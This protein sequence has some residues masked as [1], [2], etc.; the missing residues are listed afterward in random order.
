LINDSTY[1]ARK[2]GWVLVEIALQYRFTW[3]ISMKISIYHEFVYPYQKGGGEVQRWNIAQFLAKFGHDMKLIGY[4]GSK[5]KKEETING[6][7]IK[8]VGR[9]IDSA[10][11]IFRRIPAVLL[12][13][14]EIIK[15]DSDVILTNPFFPI[16]F[17]LPIAKLRHKKVCVTWDDVFDYTTLKNH[18]GVA[19]GYL[20]FLLEYVGLF[21]TKF[22]DAV[23]CVSDSTKSKLVKAGIDEKKI[24]KILSG[25]NLEEYTVAKKKEQIVYVGRHIFYKNVEDLLRAF[26]K[27][28]RTFPKMRL[29]ILGEG[30]LTREYKKLAKELGIENS[31]DFVGFVDQKKKTKI[32]SESLCLVLPSSVEGFGLAMI[33]ANACGTPYVAYDIPAAQEITNITNG[34]LLAKH[35]NVED[36]TRKILYL[37]KNR[38]KARLIGEAG[39]KNVKETFTWEITSKKV[40]NGIKRLY[41]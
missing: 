9:N 26:S 30:E 1:Y 28:I 38:S 17:T 19:L 5:T 18:S 37:L 41:S 16:I 22:S 13:V 32:I 15:D 36:L 35:G 20:G 7:Y 25:I 12:M 40:E 4:R 24:I 3:V 14:P 27:V 33:E 11:Q 6:V 23:F 39:R 10:S 29:E 8:R 34:G 31:V 21:L 2:H